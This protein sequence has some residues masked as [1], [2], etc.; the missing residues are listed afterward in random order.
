MAIDGDIL[1]A[2][3]HHSG[4]HFGHMARPVILKYLAE[5][6][7]CPNLLVRST[8][9]PRFM[10]LVKVREPGRRTTITFERPIDGEPIGKGEQFGQIEILTA[11]RQAVICGTHASGAAIYWSRI[12]DPNRQYLAP[13]IDADTPI[14]DTVE[15]IADLILDAMQPFADKANIRCTVNAEKH[16]S[17]FVNPQTP[18]EAAPPSFDLWLDLI[19]RTPNPPTSDR[20]QWTRFW[21]AFQGCR[22]ALQRLGRLPADRDREVINAMLDWSQR[23]EAPPGKDRLDR[24]AEFLKFEGD[25]GGRMDIRLGWDAMVRMA[26]RTFGL[27]GFIAGMAADQF[28]AGTE[29]D[30][31][32]GAIDLDELSGKALPVEN[33]RLAGLQ[34]AE[35]TGNPSVRAIDLDELSGKALPVQWAREFTLESPPEIVQ[36]WLGAGEIGVMVGGPGSFKTSLVAGLAAAM[37]HG[38]PWLGQPTMQGGVLVVEMEG[39]AGF[40]RR[41]LAWHHKHGMNHANVPVGMISSSVSLDNSE[42]VQAII[43]AAKNME[44]EFGGTP[45][46]LIIIDTLASTAG[47]LDENQARDMG[48]YVKALSQI[49]APTGATVLIIHHTGLREGDRGRGSSALRGAWDN[50][51]LVVKD[52]SGGVIKPNKMRERE[53]PKPIAFTAEILDLGVDAAGRTVKSAVCVLAAGVNPS[54]PRAEALTGATKVA[55]DALCEEVSA[56]GE[57][58]PPGF[59]HPPSGV[60]ITEDRFRNA[61]YQKQT[62]DKTADTRRKAF[63]R[64]WNKLLELKLIDA[65]NGWV[66]S[67]DQPGSEF[68]IEN[69]KLETDGAGC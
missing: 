46:R 34:L 55:F 36:G 66:W 50:E 29:I 13:L 65:G 39:A 2:W 12:N 10:I 28:A 16:I 48:I 18:E 60:G 61:F 42:Q 35:G 11:N 5:K 15:Q 40:R 7:N 22:L 68:E 23:W 45:V 47:L 24:E 59:R 6:M 33:T 57:K 17:A 56:H 20:E 3:L 51:L 8:V 67:M 43:Q 25:F 14:F 31:A 53:F 69:P 1:P 52:A 19:K 64:V 38:V 4:Q 54:V 32:V 27:D 49:R 58:L 62:G 26:T 30:P 9:E 63:S 21:Y 37:G 41:F 44:R